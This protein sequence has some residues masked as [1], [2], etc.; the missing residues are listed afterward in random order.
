MVL[1]VHVETMV[2][3]ACSLI[4]QIVVNIYNDGVVDVG[5]NWGKWPV[6]IDT[7]EDID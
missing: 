5:N 7:C 1:V 2:V 4:A 3:N 6:S